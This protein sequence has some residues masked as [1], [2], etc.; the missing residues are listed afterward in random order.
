MPLQGPFP[1]TFTIKTAEDGL[2]LLEALGHTKNMYEQLQGKYP[3][4][5]DVPLWEARAKLCGNLYAEILFAC[6]DD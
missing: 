4:D 6:G 1:A 2:T 3:S 5:I